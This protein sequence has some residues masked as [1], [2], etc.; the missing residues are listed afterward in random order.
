MDKEIEANFL[1][2]SDTRLFKASS[3]H[4]V[5]ISVK[6]LYKYLASLATFRN[7]NSDHDRFDFHRNLDITQSI[8]NRIKLDLKSSQCYKQLMG[9][10]NGKQ[11]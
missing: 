5:A 1:D 10:L 6:S 9:F 3:V 2:I 8:K 7:W 4:G 11:E